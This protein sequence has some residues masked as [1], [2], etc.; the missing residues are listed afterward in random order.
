VGLVI[1]AGY[2]IFFFQWPEAKKDPNAWRT[3]DNS[4]MAYIMMQDFVKDRLKSPA[5]AKFPG[6]REIEMTKD[7]FEYSVAAYVDSQNTFGAMLR[8]QFFG[9]LRQS[10]KDNW[11]LI[12]LIFDD[13]I[14]YQAKEAME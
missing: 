7:G 5:S 10:D 13:E 1:V 2:Y 8:I 9:V 6:M 4:T 11:T 14:I 12:L 3:E